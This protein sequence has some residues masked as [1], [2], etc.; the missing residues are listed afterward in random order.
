[1]LEIA[2]EIMGNNALSWHQNN[3]LRNGVS[4]IERFLVS[5]YTLLAAKS[6]SDCLIAYKAQRLY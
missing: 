5:H 2:V 3:L 4:G 1:M 6:N